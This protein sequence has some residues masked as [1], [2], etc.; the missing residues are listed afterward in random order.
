[1]PEIYQDSSFHVNELETNTTLLM[2]ETFIRTGE[3]SSEY[4]LDVEAEY[5]EKNIERVELHYRTNERHS[6]VCIIH[7]K[8]SIEK[9]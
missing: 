4:M 3:I 8:E 7:K 2:I 6:M 5:L 1:L 9:E